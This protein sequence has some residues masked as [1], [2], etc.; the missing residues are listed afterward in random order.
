MRKLGATLAAVAIAVAGVIGLIAFFDSR[1][2]ST[3]GGQGSIPAPGVE[4]PASG[5]ALLERGNVV[6]TFSD[7]AFAPKLR[8]LASELGAPDTPE[9]RAVGQA[10]VIR[11]APKAGG[12]V[13]RGHRH[14]LTVASPADPQLQDFIERW[15]GQAASG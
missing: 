14:S 10:V 7:P 12:V 15:L 5:D 2:N 11:R 13:A 3:T 4:A 1:D 9:L 6:L 8:T